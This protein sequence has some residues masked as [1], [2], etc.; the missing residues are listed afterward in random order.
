MIRTKDNGKDVEIVKPEDK[1][2]LDDF[3]DF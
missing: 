2:P 1:I 3:K